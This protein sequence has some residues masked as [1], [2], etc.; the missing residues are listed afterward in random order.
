MWKNEEYKEKYLKILKDKKESLEDSSKNIFKFE[1]EMNK[2]KDKIDKLEELKNLFKDYC[3]KKESKKDYEN[4]VEK[5]EKIETEIIDKIHQNNEFLNNKEKELTSFDTIE[6]NLAN[7]S[8]EKNKI[9]ND[10]KNLD[11]LKNLTEE[12]DE[13]RNEYNLKLVEYDKIQKD[14]EAQYKISKNLIILIKLIVL[15]SFFPLFILIQINPL[16]QCCKNTPAVTLTINIIFCT[17]INRTLVTI[18]FLEI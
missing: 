13:T 16:I 9:L 15:F 7:F 17:H 1:N 18:I 2:L 12:L 5:L 10:L 8:L 11:N 14:F 3:E 6:K 4:K